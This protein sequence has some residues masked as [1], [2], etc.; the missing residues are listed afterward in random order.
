MGCSLVPFSRF[1]IIMVCKLSG[2]FKV[3]CLTLGADLVLLVRQPLLHGRSQAVIA[4]F[5]CQ[6]RLPILLLETAKKPF[7]YVRCT[8]L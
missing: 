7:P 8:A 5:Q 1:T 6:Q 4:A 2:S 3:I